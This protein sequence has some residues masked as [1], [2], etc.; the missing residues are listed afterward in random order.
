KIALFQQLHQGFT[1]RARGADYGDIKRLAHSMTSGETGSGTVTATPHPGNF[2]RS[3]KN[4][5]ARPCCVEISLT[6]ARLNAL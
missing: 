2:N 6:A 5:C 3:L 4:Y 1:E